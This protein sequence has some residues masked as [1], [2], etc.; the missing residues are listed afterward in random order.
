[1]K[2][3]N[4]TPLQGRIRSGFSGRGTHKS[5][6]LSGVVILGVVPF[7]L[8]TF[9]AS[10]TVGSGALEFGQGSQQAIACDDTVFAA[11]SQEW[12][13]QPT[14]LDSSAGFFR[15]KAI[16]ISD[17]DLVSCKG[18]KLRV[19]LIDTN[20]AEIPLGP[21]PE[22]TA[23]QIVLAD[24]DAP[25]STSN[26]VELQLTYLASDGSPFP[27]QLLATASINTTGTSVYDGADLTA[28]S[29]DV[30][31]YLDSTATRVNIDGQNVGRVTV[32]TINN[33]S[34]R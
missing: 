29:S 15:V 12:H 18:K 20:G 5:K 23:L 17:L 22:E 32:E 34:R 10:V 3:M 6:I 8:S 4:A 25:I 27:D 11:V 24:T 21:V 28:N 1:M 30:T 19:R 26:S 31:F 33:P 9:A 13:S 16:T 2:D 14:D 7:I